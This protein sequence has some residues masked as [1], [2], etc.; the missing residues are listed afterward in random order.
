MGVSSGKDEHDEIDEIGMINRRNNI[1]EIMDLILA[2]DIQEI[3]AA[4][5]LPRAHEHPAAVYLA[6]LAPRSRLAIE[7]TLVVLTKIAS[8]GQASICS[9]PWTT[10]CYQHVSALRAQLA[11]RY[12]LARANGML[13]ALRGVMKEC[14]QLEL[15]MA[16][17][18]RWVK[19]V[20]AVKGERLPKGHGND[21]DTLRLRIAP[22][23]NGSARPG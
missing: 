11:E 1:A 23:R 14:W 6:R 2:G 13:A 21:R 22:K 5:L 20:P 15:T 8:N 9:F 17:E 10:L 19:V 18:Y 12:S 4:T 7:S 3:V 16:E